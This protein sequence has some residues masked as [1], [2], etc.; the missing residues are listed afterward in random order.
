VPVVVPPPGRF[1]MTKVWPTCCCTCSNTARG[2]RSVALPAPNGTTIRTVLV[3][4][5]FVCESWAVA[6]CAEITAPATAAPVNIIAAQRT[7]S[8]VTLLVISVPP[9]VRSLRAGNERAGRRPQA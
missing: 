1:S 2:T 7:C 4:Q 8:V 3:G 6:C 5:A 9:P